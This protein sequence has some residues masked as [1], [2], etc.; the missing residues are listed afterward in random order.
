MA[1]LRGF[2]TGGSA[3]LTGCG[4]GGG[5]SA[6]DPDAPPLGSRQA[7]TI[8]SG[9]P[10]T[11]YPLGLYLPTAGAGPRSGLPAVYVLDGESW[12]DTMA[13][14]FDVAGTPAMLV[15]VHG[16]GMRGRDYLPVVASVGCMSNL[17][18]GWDK[19]C[20]A[21]HTERPVPL[22]LSSASGGNATAVTAFS[23]VVERRRYARFAL[24]SDACA[25]THNGIVPQAFGEGVAFGL[26]GAT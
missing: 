16:A 6:P 17:V 7:L 5:G 9:I 11:T 10:G 12:F 22:H 26:A 14:L 20:A 13:N 2:L 24:K 4:G 19:A 3:S 8:R 23:Q 25:G 15:A 1:S 18:Y 21:V